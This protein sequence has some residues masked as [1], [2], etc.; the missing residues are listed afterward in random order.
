MDKRA[1]AIV[2][3]LLVAVPAAVC[4]AQDES[5]AFD[6]TS[7]GNPVDLGAL[8]LNVGETKKVDIRNNETAYADYESYTM[9]FAVKNNGNYTDIVTFT[10]TDGTSSAQTVGGVKVDV[11]RQGAGND[12][13]FALNLTG[14]TV[15]A[16]A[17]VLIR[18]TVTVTE[19]GNTLT[20]EIYYKVSVTVIGADGALTFT[21]NTIT[22]ISGENVSA[23]VTASES[24]GI[25]AE[26]VYAYGLPAGLNVSVLSLIHI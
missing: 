24:T 12:G 18:C 23:T 16:A 14:A 13:K 15:A 11:A 10:S 25:N 9:A 3:A 2:L 21:N 26:S 20:D 1:L 17:D 8:T 22:A 4:M 19:N 6:G 7:E 5:D